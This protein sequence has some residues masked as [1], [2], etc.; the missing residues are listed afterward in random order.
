VSAVA[1]IER[2]TSAEVVV[3]IRNTSGAYRHSYHVAG[4]ITAFVTLALLVYLPQPFAIEFWLIQVLAAYAMG[5]AIA[6]QLPP[7]RRLLISRRAQS[8]AVRSEARR[9]F[10]DLDVGRTRDR[11][12]VL[13]YV[14]LFEHVV[15]IVPDRGV[16]AVRPQWDS[17]VAALRAAFARGDS[18]AFADALRTLGP[19]L[20]EVLPRKHD[21]VDELEPMVAE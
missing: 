19:R 5:A 20:A 10:Y 17:E 2:Q 16:A 18:K 15:E 8:G 9:A 1:D 14:S 3:T 4:A 11:T 21:D 7:L 13:V 6:W 12:G